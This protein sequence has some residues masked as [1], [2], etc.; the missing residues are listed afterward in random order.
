[1]S[2]DLRPSVGVILPCLNEASNLPYV[3]SRMPSDVVEVV[4]VD[5]VSTDGTVE[6]ARE[7]WPSVRVVAQS[8][9]GK[10]NA[11]VC[12]FAASTTDIVVTLDADGSAD[13]R[14]IPRFVR[15]LVDGADVAKGSRYLRDGGS[16]DLT[17]LRRLG[18][19]ALTALVNRL[20]RTRYTDLCYGYNA[21]WR[22]VVPCLNLPPVDARGS[23]G[24]DGSGGSG[25]DG[26]IWGD[27]FE[28]ETL[29]HLRGVQA[30][31]RQVEVPSYEAPRRNGASNLRTYRDGRRVLATIL[32]ERKAPAQ[33]EVP[34]PAP[35]PTLAPK[36]RTPKRI[37]Q[38]PVLDGQVSHGPVNELSG[39]S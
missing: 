23:G 15:A 11:L 39:G 12:G 30:G 25:G 35:A 28:I 22:R 21:L 20:F 36:Q 26:P 29:L 1:M 18:N 4:L 38:Q 31:L 37:P 33:V 9:R 13:P 3:F 16:D 17:R 34:V 2:A 10:G 24:A 5:G 8:R 32:R 14:E 7:L 19:S 6:A 27:G